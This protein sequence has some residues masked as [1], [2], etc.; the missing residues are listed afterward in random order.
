MRRLILLGP[1]L[2]FG[3]AG[4]GPCATDGGEVAGA[5][6]HWLPTFLQNGARPFRLADWYDEFS[7]RLVA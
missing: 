5:G 6:S 3:R 7:I 1:E 4:S 2:R